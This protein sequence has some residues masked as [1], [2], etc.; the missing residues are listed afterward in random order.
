[1][2]ITGK[3]IQ[4]LPEQKFNGKNGE[5]VKHSFVVS[6]MDGQYEQKLCLE[7]ISEDKFDKM[8]NAAVVGHD[9]LVKFN[10]TSREYQGRWFTTASCYYCSTIGGVQQPQQGASAQPQNAPQQN[11]DAHVDDSGLPF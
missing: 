2:E 9:V 11:N 4:V 3:I 10:V 1:M 6:W 8:K 5:I 7:V